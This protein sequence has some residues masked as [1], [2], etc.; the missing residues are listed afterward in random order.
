MR[1]STCLPCLL[2]A[3]VLAGAAH[4]DPKPTRAAY[5][6]AALKA[7]AEPLA[8]RVRRGDAAA[9]AHLMPIVTASF[10]LIGSAYKQGLRSPQADELMQAAEKSQSQLP[11]AEFVRVQDACQTEAQQLLSSVSSIERRLVNH[12]ARSRVAKL[13]KPSS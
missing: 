2:G 8:E 6:V 10:A 3:A 13:R 11:P 1:L 7:R 4:A 9:E 5:C 12:A